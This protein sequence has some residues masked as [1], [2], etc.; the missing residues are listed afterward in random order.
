M[1]LVSQII[2]GVAIAGI[3]VA[4]ADAPF[5]AGKFGHMKAVLDVCGRLAPRQASGYLL[6][7]KSLIADASKAMVD[8]A[9]RT[10]AYQ[11]AYESTR[12]TLSEL[13]LDAVATTCDEY[14]KS[15]N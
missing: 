14:L 3:A 4:R 8:E 5:D 9:T 12:S 6:E 2:L 13:E 11:Q 7:M 15:A 1:N 10:D